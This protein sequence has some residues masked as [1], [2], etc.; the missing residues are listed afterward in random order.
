MFQ[1]SYI[2]DVVKRV[3]S[4]AKVTLADFGVLLTSD[5]AVHHREVPH[6]MAGRSLMALGAVLR[7]HGRM[8]IAREPPAGCAVTSRA[9]AS[10]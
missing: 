1:P 3:C 4:V 9:V 10:E 7:C 6:V 2:L 5:H 8:D